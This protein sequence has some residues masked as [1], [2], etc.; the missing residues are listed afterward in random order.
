MRS[1]K[2]RSDRACLRNASRL[3]SISNR[4]PIAAFFTKSAVDGACPAFSVFAAPPRAFELAAPGDDP[5]GA[6][7]D[8]ADCA[9]FD[10]EFAAG[11]AP[12]CDRSCGVPFGA[13][14]DTVLEGACAKAGS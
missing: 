2:R 12:A 3:D 14:G 11:G 8:G 10:G 1:A 6:F 13:L 9:R 5:P 7:G 4:P